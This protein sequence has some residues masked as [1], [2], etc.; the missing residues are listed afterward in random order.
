MGFFDIRPVEEFLECLEEKSEPD[1]LRKVVCENPLKGMFRQFGVKK[2]DEDL[3][4]SGMLGRSDGGKNPPRVDAFVSYVNKILERRVEIRNFLEKLA[5]NE[6]TIL[7]KAR[8]NASKYL[9]EQASF[10]DIEVF[11]IPV[12]YDSRAEKEGIFFDPLLAFDIGEAGLIDYLSREFH[13]MGRDSTVHDDTFVPRNAEELAFFVFRKF[14][15][16]GIADLVFDVADLPVFAGMK[17][18]RRKSRKLFSI[19]TGTIRSARKSRLKSKRNSE[20]MN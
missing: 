10:E 6:K 18:E 9:P 13:H 15:I 19:P 14:E 8:K 3:C 11:F 20:K 2:E 7:S 12:P 16:E 1:R 4:F 5:K 17:R